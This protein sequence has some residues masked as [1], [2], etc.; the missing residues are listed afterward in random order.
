MTESEFWIY[1]EHSCEKGGVSG[2]CEDLPKEE[3]V[4]IGRLLLE[5]EVSNKAKSI[6]MMTLAHQQ[7]SK[8]AVS[9]LRQYNYAPDKGLEVFAELALDE[10]EWWN[11]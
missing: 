10:C 4:Q 2:Y 1:F 3:I 6:I 11:E 5:K 9:F 7:N 8:E